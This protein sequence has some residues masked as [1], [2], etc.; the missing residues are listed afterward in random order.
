MKIAFVVQRYGMEI[1][2]GAELHC[3]Y[4]AEHLTRHA[5]VEVITTCAKDYITWKNSYREGSESMNGVT[6]RRFRV[7][8]ERNPIAYGRLQEHIIRSAHSE[9]DELRWMDEQGPYSSELIRFIKKN[10]NQ[11][12]HFIFFSYRYYHSF[13][14]IR[15]VPHKSILVPTAE[16]DAVI[17]FGIFRGLF[18]LPQAFV[19]NSVEERRLIQNI[20]SNYQVPGDVVGVGSRIPERSD[21]AAFRKKF[22]IYSPFLIYVGRIDQ[23]KGCGE[24]FDFFLKYQGES[25]SDLKLVLIGSPVMKL[26]NNPAILHLGFLED[27]DKFNA[28][29][30]SEMLIM[31]SQYESLSM[32]LLEAWGMGKPTLAN[33]NCRVLMG[34]SIRSNAGLFYTDYQEFKRSLDLLLRR[35]DI[36]SAFGRNGRRFYDENYRWDIIEQKY[37]RIMEA[38]KN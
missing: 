15:A 12:Q 8:K 1:N 19:Y 7:D 36:R 13:H 35:S 23:N 4:V 34:Q 38:V 32:V 28:L 17:H 37:L 3:R 10:Q 24:L 11:Y 16:P 22:G 5:E 14:G 25:K 29:S 31:P 20:S 9:E 30:A 6:V 33:G 27:E 18:H 21:P 2:G 26:P